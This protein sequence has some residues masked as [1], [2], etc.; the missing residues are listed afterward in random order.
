MNNHELRAAL[1]E[2]A[3]VLQRQHLTA[4]VYVVGG[5]AM[6]LAYG[7]DR[8]TRDIDALILD[9]HGPVIDAVR[10]VAQ[11]R[12]LPGSW[13][14]EQASVYMASTDDTARVTVFDHPSLRVLAAS[15][16][17]LLAMKAR[18]ARVTDRTDIRQLAQMVGAS[19]VAEIS[20]IVEAVFPGEPLSE[21]S[22]KVVEDFLD[23]A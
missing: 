5:A 20:E 12:G 6:V 11:R 8:S 7:A 9:H 2:V 18:A 17:H 21:R 23:D 4:R 10:Q 3:E 14:N 22:R 1:S 15:P 13:L 19:D 16:R